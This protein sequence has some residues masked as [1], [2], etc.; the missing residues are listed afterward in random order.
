[1]AES[2]QDSDKQDQEQQRGSRIWLPV[3]LHTVAAIGMA[4]IGFAGGAVYQGYKVAAAYRLLPP[5]PI[6]H[7]QSLDIQAA[8]QTVL[9]LFTTTVV[10]VFGCNIVQYLNNTVAANPLIQSLCT[11]FVVSPSSF[12][13]SAVEGAA[14]GLVLFGGG[15]IAVRAL[16][17]SYPP[18]DTPPTPPGSPVSF[19]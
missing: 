6:I 7:N 10:G 8:A 12:L 16:R 3:L 18:I 13:T 19:E 17:G 1:M 14:I 11:G 4:G 9:T 5:Q 2:E 15:E